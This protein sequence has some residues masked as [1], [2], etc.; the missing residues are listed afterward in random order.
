MLFGQMR[1]LLLSFTDVE[2]TESGGRLMRLLLRVVF[3]RDGK[4]TLS[5]CSGVALHTRRKDLVTAGHLRQS[6]RRNRL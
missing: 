6:K 5:S 2:G 3:G 1:L 4:A